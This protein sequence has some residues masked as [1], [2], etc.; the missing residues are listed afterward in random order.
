MKLRISYNDVKPYFSVEN[1]EI[2]KDTIEGIQLQSF[3][4]K[5]LLTIEL[6]DERWTWGR[7][8]ENGTFD[9]IIG[10]VIQ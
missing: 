3:V 10:R 9:G 7:K 1:N 5:N 8:D 2:L 4:D 6:I